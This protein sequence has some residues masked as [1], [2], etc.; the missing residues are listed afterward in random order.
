MA[1]DIEVSDGCAV[2]R[3]NTNK[4]MYRTIAS[5]PTYEVVSVV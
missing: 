5:S 2:V 3:M 4:V 1:W